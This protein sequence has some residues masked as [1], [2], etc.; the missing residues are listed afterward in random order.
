MKQE[1]SAIDP[2]LKIFLTAVRAGLLAICAAIE[3]FI[4]V[5]GKKRAE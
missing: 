2:R 1:D 5:E 3:K 4:S